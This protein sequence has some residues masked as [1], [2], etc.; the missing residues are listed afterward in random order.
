MKAQIVTVIN[1][2]TRGPPPMMMRNVN[3]KASNRDAGS[4]ESVES[5]DEKTIPLRD[6]K[7][8]EKF[9]Q[10]PNRFEEKQH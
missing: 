8:Q 3:D 5:E 7:R 1:S 4:D 2:R 10:I 6:Q 9:H